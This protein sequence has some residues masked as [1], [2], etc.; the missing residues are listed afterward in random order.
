MLLASQLPAQDQGRA[1]SPAHS[2]SSANRLVSPGVDAGGYLY[3][4]GQ[5]PRRADG[6]LPSAPDGQVRRALDHV[7][8][9][10]ES[11]GLKLENIVYVQVY[12][13]DGRSCLQ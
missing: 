12:L 4:S 1:V 10:V 11:V 7:K 3:V 13:I 8:A 9:V 2:P 5:G 6:A